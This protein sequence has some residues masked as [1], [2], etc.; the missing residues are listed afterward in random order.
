MSRVLTPIILDIETTGLNPLDSRIVAIGI[1]KLP[2]KMILFNEDEKAMIQEFLSFLHENVVLVG[3]NI[4]NF[5]IPFITA[6]TLKHGLYEE[7]AIIREVYRVDLK[8]LV[9][10]YLLTNQKCIR[11][12]K[13]CQFLDIE[14]N[15]DINGSDIPGLWE[16]GNHQAIIDHCMSDLEIT[17]KLFF[18]LEAL[19]LHNLKV[20]YGLQDVKFGYS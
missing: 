1:A 3:Y 15:D 20:R 7:I 6:R 5:D 4:N 17:K 8:A 16:Q 19:A 14:V 11:L 18:K 13:I 9:S 2:T 10:R 12:K